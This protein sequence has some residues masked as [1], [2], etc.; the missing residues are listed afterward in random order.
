M[1][2]SIKLQAARAA[3]EPSAQAVVICLIFFARQSPATNT[4]G[5]FVRQSS[6]DAIYPRS[7]SSHTE[8]NVPFD[9]TSPIATNTPS[10]RRV[11]SLPLSSAMTTAES[12]P[13][14]SKRFTVEPVI[15]ST[16]GLS[17]RTSSS[18]FSPVKYGRF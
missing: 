3:T 7:S 9:G 10:M 5:V 4:P 2:K 18:L 6:P 16:F 13:S 15:Y 12:F 11:D 8:E 1:D 14:P 17:R